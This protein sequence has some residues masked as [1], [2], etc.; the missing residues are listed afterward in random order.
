MSRPAVRHSHRAGPVRQGR[1]QRH[2]QGVT[3]GSQS[4]DY[5]LH[6]AQ[7]QSTNVSMATDNTANYFNILGRKLP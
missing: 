1:E 4:V 2:H 5:V 3:K 6:A 7:G